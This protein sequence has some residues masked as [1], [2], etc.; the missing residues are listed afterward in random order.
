MAKAFLVT[1]KCATCGQ[2]GSCEV[3]D[4]YGNPVGHFC[5]LCGD[6]KVRELN[7]EVDK[8]VKRG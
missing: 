3:F 5:K 6:R 1:H 8:R 2:R 4:Q 7:D